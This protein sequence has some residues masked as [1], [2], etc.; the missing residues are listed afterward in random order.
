MSDGRS[1][2]P[3][4]LGRARRT[5]AMAEAIALLD[6]VLTDI[7]KRRQ[8]LIDEDDADGLARFALNLGS[9]LP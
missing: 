7:R 4:S 3:P 8:E 1:S 5:Y 9:E 2:A 6:G